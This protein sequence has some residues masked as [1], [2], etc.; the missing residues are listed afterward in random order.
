MDETDEYI[1]REALVKHLT[2]VANY[3]LRSDD[4]T[5]RIVGA[6][7]M[8]LSETVE[9]IPAADVRPVV[10]GEWVSVHDGY[11][12]CSNCHRG[13]HIDPLAGFCRF[14]GADMREV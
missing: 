5:R 3:H 1:N 8:N 14:C 11:G 12:I 7:F 6:A 10:S 2:D 4:Q 9:R 13:D